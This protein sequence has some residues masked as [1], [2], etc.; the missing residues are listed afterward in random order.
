MKLNRY[1]LNLTYI[2]LFL[3]LL[4][5][6][7]GLLLNEDSL[8][9]AYHDYK[10]HENYFFKFS[11]DFKNTILNYGNNNEVRN[12]PVFYIIVSALIKLNFQI[13]YL[14]YLNILFIFL[15]SFFFLKSLKIHFKNINLDT[16]IYFFCIILLSPTIRSLT[17]HP[18]PLLWAISFFTIS[19]Y[20]FLK[21]ENS[22]DVNLRYKNSISC[23]IALSAASY[24]TP[25]F[26][27]FII[28]Y[29]IKFFKKFKFTSYLIKLSLFAFFLALPGVSFLILKDFYLFKNNV[30]EASLFEKFNIFNKLI[31][32]SSIV[33][34][35]ILPFIKK[36]QLSINS[37]NFYNIKNI[38]LLSIFLIYIFLFNF[39][40]GAGGGIFY[41]TSNLIF[42]NNY[43]LFLIFFISLIIFDSIKIYNFNNCILFLILI[44][45]NLQY[46]IYYK[47][48]D[49]ILL[50]VLLFLCKFEKKNFYN[51]NFLGKRLFIFYICF[52]LVNL[53]K[54]DLKMFLIQ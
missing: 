23:I 33:F 50:F 10:I 21:Y 2:C 47:Y 24:I 43:F 9:G 48:Y 16:Q 3:V 6:I 30:F 39:K 7:C 53:F 27:V 34:L 28:F 31:I 38:S 32:I 15:I 46:S 44:L 45:Y 22:R 26:A 29:G 52:L 19:I 18:Y 12:S 25:N 8:A 49:P 54:N 41:Q 4:S 36:L 42:N 11:D 5:F 40:S 1:N 17:I 14:R 35:F 37:R 20:Y 51:I 13:E